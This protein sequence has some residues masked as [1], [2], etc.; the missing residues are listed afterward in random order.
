MRRMWWGGARSRRVLL[1]TSEQ[2][3]GRQQGALVGRQAALAT[4]FHARNGGLMQAQPVSEF[5]LGNPQGLA[6]FGDR[7]HD[8]DYM[9]IRIRPSSVLCVGDYASDGDC[10]Y[11]MIMAGNIADK[12]RAIRQSLGL[13]QTEFGEK[14]GAT[15]STVARWERGSTPRADALHELAKLAN[16]TVEKLLGISELSYVKTGEIPVVGYVGAGAEI[17]P[18][19]DFPKG[20]GMDYIERPPGVE[21]EA[22]AVEVRGDSLFPTAENG[23]RLIYAGDQTVLEDDVLNRLCVVKL[24]DGR[25]L[26]KRLTRGSQPQRYH[27]VSTNAPMIED[28]EIMWAARVKAIIP[29]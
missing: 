12:I 7:F 13:N 21:G 25:V 4:A 17:L 15:Q 1:P 11:P 20:E 26:V 27:L 6:D 5:G 14:L 10:A 8:D 29:N 2:R 24:V 22:I 9:R 19:D 18:F 16:T 28:A 3:S 23:W